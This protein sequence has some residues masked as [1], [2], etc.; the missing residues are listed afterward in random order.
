M[1]LSQTIGWLVVYFQSVYGCKNWFSS[2][3]SLH[4]K[5]ILAWHSLYGCGIRS[6]HRT[7]PAEPNTFLKK[8]KTIQSGH[9]TLRQCGINVHAACWSTLHWH[10]YDCVS[11]L[12]ANADPD[13]YLSLIWVYPALELWVIMSQNCSILSTIFP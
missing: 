2:G 9:T 3:I 1:I 7:Y 6:L 8:M 5:H 10:W 13:Q 11:M 4:R 12:C